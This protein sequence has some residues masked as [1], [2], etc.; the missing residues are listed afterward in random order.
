MLAGWRGEAGDQH[1]IGAINP[2]Q[3][4]AYIAN[5]CFWRSEM[6]EGAKYFKHSN[7]E[8]L[9]W[10]VKMGLIDKAEPIVLQLYSEVLQKFRLAAKGH[11]K[12]QPPEQH[13]A[14]VATYFD[15][16]PLWYMPFEEDAVDR[17]E[18]PMHALT[19]RPMAM[20]HSWGSQNAWLRQIHGENRLHIN[21]KRAEA[22]GLADDDWVYLTSHHSRIKVQIKLMEG[23]NA[24][25]VW[26]WN[27]I[28]KRAGAWNLAPDAGESQRGFLMNHLISELLP[29]RGGQRYSNSD[30][31]TGQAAWYDLRVRIE[32]APA[33]AEV[34]EPHFAPTKPLPHLPDRPAVLRY[35]AKFRA[36]TGT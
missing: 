11:G 20:Y 18:F 2:K 19:Q 17:G 32:K 10:A 12:V 5:Q 27:A 13:R 30:P 22:L 33:E 25:T 4:E 36:R 3:L 14:R 9:D 8:Y 34:T 6:P 24:D 35:G 29:D 15:P 31:V 23:V 28:G 1:G 7:Q 21:R 26:T 16:L